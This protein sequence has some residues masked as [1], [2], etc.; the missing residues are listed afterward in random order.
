MTKQYMHKIYRDS[1][2]VGAVF[3]AALAL[4]G[5]YGC[6]NDAAADE[7]G[8]PETAI[9]ST[10]DSNIESDIEELVTESVY[11]PSI[12]EGFKIINYKGGFK[13]IRVRDGRKYLLIPNEAANE[14]S[15][16]VAGIETDSK[17]DELMASKT[18]RDRI[19]IHVPAE[20]IYLAASAAM[21]RFESLGAMDNVAYSGTRQEDWEIAAAAAAMER[22]DILYAGKYSQ[23]D[24]EMLLEGG[25]NLAIENAMILHKP[26]NID[27]LTELSIPVLIDL[28]SMETEPLGRTEWIVV[29][30]ALTGHEE[31]AVRIFDEQRALAEDIVMP[32][33]AGQK[34]AWFYVNS[35]G[36]IVC[37]KA[38]SAVAKMIGYA[39]GEYAAAALPDGDSSL[40]STIKLD[41]ESFMSIAGDAD[42]L[43]YDAAINPIASTD[44][45]IALNPLFAEFKAVQ[46]ASLYIAGTSM[47]QNSDKAGRLI[48]D[49]NAML[50]NSSD[51]EYIR[52]A[53]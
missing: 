16:D 53:D 42:Y 35:Q 15:N 12:A 9:E 24:Y 38:D 20:K 13:E 36:Q 47:Y 18:I 17:Y 23:P 44:E 46:N 52:R 10:K 6:Q 1:I 33:T 51:M 40:M 3:T 2:R 28:S 41:M 34:V 5:L 14:N 27:K 19:I 48:A 25:C 50:R 37:Q 21:C 31:E 8:T 4:F 22:G 49:F 45:L 32:D 26:E 7:K 30:G 29:Y 43:V 39:G 11:E